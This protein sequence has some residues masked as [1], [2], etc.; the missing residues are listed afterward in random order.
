MASA[1][2]ENLKKN[3]GS[4]IANLWNGVK[5]LWN[6]LL[7]VHQT[8]AEKEANAF[9]EQQNQNAMDFSHEEAQEQMAFQERMANTQYQRGVAD[10]KAAGV[11]PALAMSQGGAAAP[12]G[13]AGTGSTG[14][15]VSPGAGMSMSDLIQLLTIGK[16]RKLLDAQAAAANAA[17]N[18]SNA[19]AA[20]TEK[21]TSWI[22]ATTMSQLHL[23]DS[24]IAKNGA[25][26]EDILQSAESR[27]IEN[28]YK[29]EMLEQQLSLGYVDINLAMVGIQKE[30]EAIEE[31]KANTSAAWKLAEL[32][33]RQ[34]TLVAAQVGLVRAQEWHETQAGNESVVR[35]ANIAEATNGIKLDNW[36]KS[37]D[38]AYIELTGSKP[39]VSLLNALTTKA[40]L[41][42]IQYDKR[43][44]KIL[45]DRSA[46]KK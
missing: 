39:D 41:K 19:V 44:K 24:V 18:Q 12:S 4:W 20:K 30:L 6:R 27:R 29:P 11:N 36:Q 23:N 1:F 32:R 40:Q 33:E 17:A 38:N 14:S 45:N 21:E 26:I 9:T 22:D 2:E 43:K 5:N 15:S 13:A 28:E 34:K 35:Q 31:I 42:G 37:Y 46:R 16:Q 10:M 7:G 25:Q 8:D 3:G